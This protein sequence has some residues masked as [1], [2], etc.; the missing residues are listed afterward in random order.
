[1]EHI[2]CSGSHGTGDIPDPNI[3]TPRPNPNIRSS[4]PS[5]ARSSEKTCR[6]RRSTEIRAAFKCGIG[7]HQTTDATDAGTFAA[8][9]LDPDQP[10]VPRPKR[11]AWAH[12]CH[13]PQTQSRHPEHPATPD[14]SVGMKSESEHGCARLTSFDLVDLTPVCIQ[15]GPLTAELDAS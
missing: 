8:R 2:H 1:M 11:G 13:N 15:T 12:C 10:A 14:R 9:C 5:L 7:R 3:Q 4:M 6:R